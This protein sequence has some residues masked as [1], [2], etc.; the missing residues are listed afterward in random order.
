[1]MILTLAQR[2]LRSLFLSPLAW[3]ILAIVQFILAYLFLS[4]LQEFLLIQNKLATIE[5]A[6]GVTELVIAPLYGSATFIMM[7][8][9][10]LLTMRLISEERRN[11]SLALLLSAPVSMTEII[12]GK[13]LGML[14]F[15]AIMIL[16]MTLMPLSLYLTGTI[17]GGLLFTIVLGITLLLAAFISVG[18]YM[19]SLTAQPTIAAMST[20]GILLMLWI[21][22]WAGG[23]ASETAS[24]L[25]EYLSI[26]R[27]FE[28]FSKG[29]FNS[30]DFIYYV[31]FISLFLILSIRRLDSD[32]LQR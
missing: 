5:N 9:T 7:L 32:R 8:V 6:P 20:F 21:V 3:A 30:S 28:A 4:Q 15:A 1:M 31:L 26:L 16:M 17:D 2:E 22:D 24:G 10:P 12:I 13:Y 27:H 11:K 14:G 19:S 29:V 18:L 25:L 23:K